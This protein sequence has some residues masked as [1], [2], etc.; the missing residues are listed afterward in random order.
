[1]MEF[2]CIHKVADIPPEWDWMADNYFQQIKFLTH[3]EKH[4][5]CNQ[6]YYLLLENGKLIAGAIVYS[7]RLDILTFARLKSPIKMNI[8]GIPC[9]VSC[10]GL[11]GK[12][13]SIE[14]LKNHIYI[15]EKGFVLVLNL[16]NKLDGSSIASG[17]TLPSIIF[18][19]TFPNWDNYISSLRSNYR[20]RLKQINKVGKEL[21]FKKKSCSDFSENMHKQYLDV[22]KRSKG[23]LEK[24]SLN[25]F[26]NLPDEFKLTVCYHKDII[27]GWNIA[28]SDQNIYYFFFGG[29]DYQQNKNYSTYFQ[30]LIN[31]IKDGVENRSEY[32]ELGQTA[33]IPKMRM[34]GKPKYLY[35]EAHHSNRAF[36]KILKLCNPLLE[37]KQ[38]LEDTKVFRKGLI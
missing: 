20:R 7:L 30:L 8:I 18:S 34:G 14:I 23:K 28:L 33:E 32:I 13:D 22:Y 27:I 5:P 3:T 4:N 19:N 17:K 15:V 25:F 10:Q 26:K 6:R 21:V 9:S 16:E 35:M 29:I 1:M 2:K 36:N 11:F 37:Y 38:K 12:R 24:L 31:L